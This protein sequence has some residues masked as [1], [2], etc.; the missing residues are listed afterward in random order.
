M[1]CFEEEQLWAVPALCVQSQLPSVINL[2]VLGA[3]NS[4]KE[5]F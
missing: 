2:P 5:P 1:S 4:T 3:G